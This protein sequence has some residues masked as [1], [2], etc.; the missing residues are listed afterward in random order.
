MSNADIHSPF[1]QAGLSPRQYLDA[2]LDVVEKNSIR[3][4]DLIYPQYSKPKIDWDAY[5]T[6][7]TEQFDKES[8]QTIEE[9]VPILK[10]ALELLGDG[11]SFWS[12]F[13]NYDE[14]T[15]LTPHPVPYGKLIR[16]DIG[17]LHLPRE[18]PDSP[19]HAR[20]LSHTLRA[21]LER[22]DARSLKGW[23]IDL[24]SHT[25]GGIFGSLSALLPLIKDYGVTGH[26]VPVERDSWNVSLENFHKEFEHDDY[27]LR[28]RRVP[29]AVLQ[30][31]Y[32][33]SAGE[34][35]AIS[36]RGLP[37]AKS[38]GTESAG[39][40]T[41]NSAFEMPDGQVVAL[42]TC[43]MADRTGHVYGGKITPDYLIPSTAKPV[44]HDSEEFYGFNNAYD[45]ASDHTFMGA[46]QWCRQQ[47]R[48]SIINEPVI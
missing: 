7:I 40:T 15:K 27:A 21:E 37:H 4:S 3:G 36:F 41:G 2:F 47:G 32:T 42:A 29:I 22:L 12:G 23:V 20:V 33:C 1:G 10:D 30:G 5:R 19:E 26:F 24:R 11:H 46:T 43:V 8:P 35:M 45:I 16:G 13:E 48:R 28:N 17:Y 18:T 44:F 14:E 31:D 38:F 39:M 34:A 9:V 25:G 6:A